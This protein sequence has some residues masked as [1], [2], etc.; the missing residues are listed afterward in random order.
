MIQDSIMLFDPVTK[1]SKPFPSHA[2]QYRYYNG[3]IPWKY[4]PW[5]GA[6]RYEEDIK[7]DPCGLN[8]QVES[9]TR[10]VPS[11]YQ[12]LQDEFI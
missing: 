9:S 5:T 4:N 1:M 3:M 8:I 11:W 10:R 7:T 12:E 2:M 6:I